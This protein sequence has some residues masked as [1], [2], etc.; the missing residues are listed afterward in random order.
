[1]ALVAV[2]VVIMVS[3]MKWVRKG[4]YFEIF[5]WAHCLYIFYWILLILHAPNFWK[6]FIVP[7]ILFIIE[8]LYRSGKGQMCHS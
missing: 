1:M 6:W 5:W 4:G 8:K 7:C 3:S 2:L